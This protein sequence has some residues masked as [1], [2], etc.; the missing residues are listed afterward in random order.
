LTK[1]LGELR[2]GVAATRRLLVSRTGTR[3]DFPT[4]SS[5]ASTSRSRNNN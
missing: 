5:A 4:A 3:E 1:A 2:E